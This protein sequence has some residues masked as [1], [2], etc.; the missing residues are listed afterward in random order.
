MAFRKKYRPSGSS[1]LASC[2]GETKKV[3]TCYNGGKKSAGVGGAGIENILHYKE[4]RQ[5]TNLV[6]RQI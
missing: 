3:K 4:V 2:G 5:L 1:L 6:L